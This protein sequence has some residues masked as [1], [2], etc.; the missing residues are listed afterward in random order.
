LSA[1]GRSARPQVEV[2]RSHAGQ[3]Q[4]ENHIRF[5]CFG[6]LEVAPP[7]SIPILESLDIQ[8]LFCVIRSI[9]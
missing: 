6:R 5:E 7:K 1:W 9:E 3:E 4:S 2:L 8:T